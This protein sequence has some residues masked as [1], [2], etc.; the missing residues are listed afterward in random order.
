MPKFDMSAS[1]IRLGTTGPQKAD[2]A[3]GPRGGNSNSEPLGQRRGIGMERGLEQQ[4]Q[5]IRDNMQALLPPKTDEVLKT[6]FVGNITEGCGGDEGMEDLLRTAGSLRKW[7]RA[8]DAD[9]KPCTFGFAE[10][11][12][13]ESLET[14]AEILKE[15]YVPLNKQHPKKYDQENGEGAET[16]G[17]VEKT[18]LLVSRFRLNIVLRLANDRTRS[19]SMTRPRPTQKTGRHSE[20]TRKITSSFA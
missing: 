9:N 17:K 19:S 6:I 8:I 1:V 15:V 14:A 7:T 16:E 10:Y 20:A 12:D 3:P 18:K 13:S 4:R 2:M 11:E 5:Q